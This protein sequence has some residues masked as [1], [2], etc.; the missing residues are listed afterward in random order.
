MRGP[1]KVVHEA[2]HIAGMVARSTSC[3]SAE[4]FL[5]DQNICATMFTYS[6]WWHIVSGLG[7]PCKDVFVHNY[8]PDFRAMKASSSGAIVPFLHRGM[9]ARRLPDNDEIVKIRP[10]KYEY[11]AYVVVNS[12]D[13]VERQT[14]NT[15]VK[16]L[17]IVDVAAKRVDDDVVFVADHFTFMI[18][19]GDKSGKKLHL[20]R[21]EYIPFSKETGRVA[22]TPN[23]LP[24]KF[25]LPSSADTFTNGPMTHMNFKPWAPWLHGIL[26][27]HAIPQDHQSG[28]GS[29]RRNRKK[30]RASS[31]VQSFDDIWWNLPIESIWVF[32][33][34]TPDQPHH[35]DVSIIVKDR[36]MKSPA[37]MW[38]SFHAR[39]ASSDAATAHGIQQIVAHAMRDMTWADFEEVLSD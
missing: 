39:V 5:V 14:K 3:V 30:L 23:H 1:L 38:P 28:G 15:R 6:S 7:E 20:H 26:K 34:P 17:Y 27:T 36:L 32:A 9:S 10:R 29:K 37:M 12:A 4:F 31:R 25:E 18:N 8:S 33:V 21:T 24:L 19:P 2:T 35:H 22:R 11:G 16:N 13:T